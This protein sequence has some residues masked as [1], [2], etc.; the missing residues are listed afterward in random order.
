MSYP[1]PDWKAKY[2]K[3]K[4]QLEDLEESVMYLPPAQ[5]AVLQKQMNRIGN[6]HLDNLARIWS[7]EP[8]LYPGVADDG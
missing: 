6:Q 3:I 5:R 7:A 2:F 8:P 1:P 4:E